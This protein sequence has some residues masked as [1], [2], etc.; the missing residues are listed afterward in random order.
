MH[1]CWTK[2]GSEEKGEHEA[3][4]EAKEPGELD[5]VPGA[6]I[7]GVVAEAVKIEQQ[8]QASIL[9]QVAQRWA[10]RPTSARAASSLMC[11]LASRDA[12]PSSCLGHGHTHELLLALP[13]LVPRPCAIITPCKWAPSL[14]P[15]SRPESHLCL[16]RAFHGRLFK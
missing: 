8:E 14:W 15:R 6:D 11:L 16:N 10:A 4:E 3:G 13:R 12:I 1:Q 7:L 2:Q 9:M 5:D